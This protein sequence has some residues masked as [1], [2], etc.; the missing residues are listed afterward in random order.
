MNCVSVI[1][2]TYNRF[3]L[4]LNTLQSIKSQT[5]S[6]IEI[7]VVNDCSTEKEYYEYKWE[8]NGIKIIHLEKNS[9]DIFS[10]ACVGHVI[11]KGIEVSSGDYIAFCDDDDIWF[12]SKIELQLNAMKI[13][14][15]NMSSTNGFI[16]IGVFDKNKLYEKLLTEYF[17][18]ILRL[19]SSLNQNFLDK[20][21][22][23]LKDGYPEIWKLDF[24]K[25]H[26]CI[27]ASSV[28]I[29]KDIISKIG[30]QLEI[31]M[32][33]ALINNTIVHID[34]DYWLR[35]LE[36]TDNAYV[37]EICVYYDAGHGS[38]KNY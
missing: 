7:I 13:T 37:N 34:Y 11:N 25:I 9:K 12:P 28:I 5:Y 24:L 10:Y 29:H 2:P 38:G 4:L 23:L 8:A 22:N 1:V 33:G 19:V 15:C 35:A 27:I 30:K 16:G 21:Y 6:N 32:G 20:G 18:S 26:N 36:Y 14:G 17:F 31:K 3:N